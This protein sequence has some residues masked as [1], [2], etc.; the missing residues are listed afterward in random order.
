MDEFRA[1]LSKF[2]LDGIWLDYHH[3]HAAWEQAKPELP[4][5]CFCARCLELFARETRIESPAGEVPGKHRDAWVKWRCGVFTDWVR[6]YRSILD[7]V[8]PKAL[9]G[10]FHC[11]WSES[12]HDGA[13]RTKLAIDLKAQSK[14]LDVLSIM[15]YHARFGHHDDPAWISRQSRALGKSLGLEGK[16][17]E[18][19]RLWPILQLS[20]WGEKV[21]ADQVRAVLDHGSRAPAT[22]VMFFHWAQLRRQPDKVAE[23][24]KFYR[25]I[26]P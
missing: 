22:G 7:A 14:Y 4:D 15:P 25:A 26:A 9:L 16:A 2:E 6:E 18:K 3:A 17:G 8:R 23:A 19:P 5:T 20:D 10:T 24:L 1:V 11:P 12:E 13:I 21:P